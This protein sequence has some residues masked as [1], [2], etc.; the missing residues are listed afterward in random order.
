[1]SST[2][3]VVW[4]DE[5]EGKRGLMLGVYIMTLFVTMFHCTA[6]SEVYSI[7]LTQKVFCINYYFPSYSQAS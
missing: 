7:I 4:F 2:Y 1:M 5:A 6:P 3:V